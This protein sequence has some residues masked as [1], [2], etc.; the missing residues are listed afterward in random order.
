MKR[1]LQQYLEDA[2]TVGRSS[3]EQTEKERH[4]RELLAHLK[5]QFGAAVIE[6]EDVRWV[7]GQIEAM[8]GKR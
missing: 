2:L 5:G 7:Y 1:S 4:Y 6:D 8:I 3:F